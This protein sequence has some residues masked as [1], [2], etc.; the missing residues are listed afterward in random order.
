[1][2]YMVSD[3]VTVVERLNLTFQ[4]DSVNISTVEPMINSTK[5]ALYALNSW[6]KRKEVS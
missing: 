5:S 6:F 3:I 1:M 4:K 2:T